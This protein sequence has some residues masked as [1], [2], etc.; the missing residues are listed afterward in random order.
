MTAARTIRTI[1]DLAIHTYFDV[2]PE[3]PDGRHVTWFAFD[4]PPLHQGRV[5][6]GDRDGGASVSVRHCDGSPHSGAH[7][8]WLDNDHIFFSSGGRLFIADLRGRIVQEFAGAID[9]VHQASRRGLFSTHN[10]RDGSAE[11]SPPEACWSMDLD[12]GTLT[13]LLNFSTAYALLREF[14]DLA[15]VAPETLT[16]KHTKWAPDGRDWFVVFTNESALRAHPGMP[17]VKVLVAARDD[18]RD[19]RIVGSFGHHPNWMPDGTG[20]Y[21]F[22]AGRENRLLCWPRAGGDP[23]T[24]AVLPCEGHPCVHPDQKR[25]A[26]DAVHWPRADRAAIVLQDLAPGANETLFEMPFPRVEWQTLHPPRCICHPHPVWSANGRR[27]YFNA[28]EG[29]TPRFCVMD[30]GAAG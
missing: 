18:G 19:A 29:E 6:I 9:T 7:Q 1:A 26:T 20:I 15:G 14:Q 21:A 30:F 2:I 16:F 5:M 22:A 23:E 11:S 10:L 13:E 4:G 24:L 27:L 12:H 28:T 8:G 25:I 17:R 3:S